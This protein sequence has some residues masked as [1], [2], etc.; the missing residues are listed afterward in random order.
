MDI[1]SQTDAFSLKTNTSLKAAA[2]CLNN[3]NNIVAE[4]EVHI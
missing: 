3:K 1:F 4:Y 2:I